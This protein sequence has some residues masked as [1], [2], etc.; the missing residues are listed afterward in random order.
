MVM[1]IMMMVMMVMVLV[2]VA[3]VA[4]VVMTKRFRVWV[5]PLHCQVWPWANPGCHCLEQPASPRRICAIT[6]GF[7]TTTWD[8]SVFQFLP[9]HYYMTYV[10]R[11]W[12][13]IPSNLWQSDLTLHQFCQALK[14]YLFGW[15]KLQHLVT[16]VYSVLYKCSYLVVVVVV[17][18]VL[19]AGPKDLVVQLTIHSIVLNKLS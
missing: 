14:T 3:A 13:S 17:M 12:N 4:L 10:S 5:S 15:L 2:M 7:Q 9:R 19:N 16:F 1:M 18:L 8:I 6:H 11:L